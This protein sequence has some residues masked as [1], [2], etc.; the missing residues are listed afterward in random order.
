M[1]ILY[2]YIYPPVRSGKP[3]DWNGDVGDLQHYMPCHSA[4]RHIGHV[5]IYIYIYI[6]IYMYVYTHVYIYIYI[7]I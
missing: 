3:R 6:Y 7:Y 4:R 1:Y 2:V 5:M